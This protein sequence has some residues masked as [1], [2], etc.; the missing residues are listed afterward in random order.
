M[1]K[2]DFL[3]LLGRAYAFPDYYLPQLDSADECL[4]DLLDELPRDRLPL[5]PLFDTL[6]A[7]VPD[8]ER[9]AILL[10]LGNYFWPAGEEE[11]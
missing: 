11:E 1:T 6:L 5:L 9:G 8:E 3:D 7:E 4:A 2:L 10:L